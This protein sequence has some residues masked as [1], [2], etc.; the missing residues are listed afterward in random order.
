MKMKKYITLLFTLTVILLVSC[1][2]EMLPKGES[3]NEYI[4]PYIEFTLSDDGTYYTARVLSGVSFENIYIPS[5]VEHN[6]RSV[7]VKYF[8]GFRNPK[9]AAKLK[10]ITLESS[11]TLITD[12][13]AG[14]A[15]ALINIEV[16][17]V[18]P[19]SVW[20][21]LPT[22]EKE[23]MDFDGWYIEGTDIKVKKG[24]NIIPSFSTIVPR[25]K[26]HNLKYIAEVKATC[27]Q[28]GTRAHYKCL[29]CQRLYSDENAEKEVILESLIIPAGHKLT[30]VEAKAANCTDDGNSAYYRCTVCRMCFSDEEG[31]NFVNEEDTVIPKKGHSLA[32]TEAKAATCTD[33]GNKEYYQCRTCSRYFYDEAC[34]AEITDLSETVIRATG[35]DWADVWASDSLSHW[36]KC[37]KCSEINDSERHSFTEE[38]T[39]K[40][41][42]MEAGEKKLT[43]GIC[44]YVKTEDI[45]PIGGNH[46]WKKTEVIEPTCRERG[47]TVYSC[48]DDDCTSTYKTEYTDALGHDLIPDEKKNATCTEDG[49]EAYWKCSR[50]S[51]LF[52]DS[53]GKNEISE[54][55]VIPQTGHNY[56]DSPYTSDETK[57]YRICANGCGTSEEAEH[58]YEEKTE[59]RTPVKS[60]TCTEGAVYTKV[61]ICGKESTETFVYGSGTGHSSPTEHRKVESNCTQQGHKTYYTCSKACCSDKF[62]SDSTLTNEVKYD[63]LLLPLADHVLS[64]DSAKNTQDNHTWVCSVCHEEIKTETHTKTWTHDFFHHHWKCSVCGY[65]SEEEGHTLKGENGRRTCECGY[66]E[67]ESQR[68]ESGFEVT[69][70]DRNPSGALTYVK[71]GTQWTFT[72]TSTNEDAPLDS[73]RWY[74]DGE[75]VAGETE[76][77]FTLDA[78]GRHSYRIM[79]VFTSG[80]RY[81]SQ[82]MTI[83]GGE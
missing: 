53:Q 60:G 7:P 31:K 56:E 72:L 24:D 29:S 76:N 35:H 67:T 78:P 69:V 20:G 62:Y 48:T 61:C 30:A 44:G 15:T 83:E 54:V 22:V 33:D 73:Y 59:G 23:G 6:G 38:V 10:T 9:D 80:G 8:D 51:K 49:H 28:S 21:E 71:N 39:K 70:I 5:Y 55:K 26:K 25:W 3:V 32:K 14:E 47:Y 19:G 46:T 79:C 57:H 18:A 63:S 17:S 16:D 75:E 12:K 43:C 74:L 2:I 66:I 58:I 64:V 27:T 34:T 65:E 82:S 1:N 41:T 81:S 11:L 13:A 4:F 40:P 68:E 36:H 77:T 50:C 42:Y 45:A 37:L 52:S